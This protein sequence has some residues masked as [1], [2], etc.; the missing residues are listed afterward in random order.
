MAGVSGIPCS[1]FIRKTINFFS[2]S[3]LIFLLY[4][5]SSFVRET[6]SLIFRLLFHYSIGRPLVNLVLCDGNVSPSLLIVGNN[7]IDFVGGDGRMVTISLPRHH[8]FVLKRVEC[9][10]RK[11]WGKN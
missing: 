11:K 7:V 9:K 2:K 10:S 5:S 8:A 3:G 6:F 1:F 4:S